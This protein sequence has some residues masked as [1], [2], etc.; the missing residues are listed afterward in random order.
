MYVYITH[1]GEHSNL[2]KTAFISFIVWRSCLHTVIAI[3]LHSQHGVAPQRGF[4][5]A[6]TT[7][8]ILLSVQFAFYDAVGSV[9][10]C[11]Q[12]GD[13]GT[14]PHCW[15]QENTVSTLCSNYV[16][17][18]LMSTVLSTVK[19]MCILHTVSSFSDSSHKVT[20]WPRI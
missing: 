4:D 7:W 1:F 15:F 9:P 19:Y 17:K 2:W 14:C 11:N 8:N 18:R 10:A 3:S 16:W 12:R 13:F 20:L 5:F 6:S